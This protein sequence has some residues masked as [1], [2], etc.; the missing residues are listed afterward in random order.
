M[1]FPEIIVIRH[2]QTEW[3]LAGIWQGARDSPLTPEGRAQARAIGAMCARLGLGRGTHDILVSPQRR[4]R[5]TAELAFGADL[6]TDPRLAE[7]DVGD[8]SGRRPADLRVE[9]GLPAATGGFDLYDRAPNGERV[10]Q[11]FDRVAPLLLNLARPTILVTHGITGRMIRT[12]AL[13][14][15]RASFADLPGGQGIA[16]RIAGGTETCLR[17][18]REDAAD[19][20]AT[21]D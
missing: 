5:H 7:I 4:A 2:G 15:P 6:P 12:L 20:A 16:W 8:W 3:N 13:G 9:L 17:P 14:R 19:P 1:S 11:V 10:A 21:L 18:A